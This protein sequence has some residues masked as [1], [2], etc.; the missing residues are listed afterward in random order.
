MHCMA[1][2][3][4][5]EGGAVRSIEPVS[6]RAPWTTCQGAE[7][8]LIATFAGLP[9]AEVTA[10]RDK[11]QNC[12]HLHDL[13]VLAAAHADERGRIDYAIFVSD[14]VARERL[15]ELRRDGVVLHSWAEQDGVLTAPA[16]IAGL[17]LFTLR[18]W[19]SGLAEPQREAARLLQWA[20]IVAHG[21]TM[22]IEQQSKAC[23]I[24][25]NC[26]TFQPARAAE[27][28]RNGLMREF[29]QSGEEPLAGFAEGVLARL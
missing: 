24:P 15:L 8:K 27:A 18:D 17:T 19:I 21:R 20:S 22:P 4:R 26:Y 11:Q 9:L 5:H 3:L 25:P 7:A 28:V 12:T 29:S 16:E 14:P 2:T 10:R 1:I 23:D 6:H 13:A